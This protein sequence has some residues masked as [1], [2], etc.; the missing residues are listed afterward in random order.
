MKKIFLIF[1]VLSAP[2]FLSQKK[3]GPKVEVQNRTNNESMKAGLQLSKQEIE[4]YNGVFLKF[5]SALK[6]SDRKG[7]DALLSQKARKMV[8]EVVYQ[9]SLIHI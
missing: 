1:S 3:A 9:L 4:L 8:T 7:M 2:F 6:T 5:I